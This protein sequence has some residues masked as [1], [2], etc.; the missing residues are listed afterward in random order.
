MNP[1]AMGTLLV[2]GFTGFFWSVYQRFILLRVGG[3]SAE[4]RCDH[5]WARLARVW[6]RAFLH[7]KLYR[8]RAAG[9]AHHLVFIGFLVL[10]VRTLIL[11]GR[12][13]DCRWELWLLPP[14]ST[15]AHVYFWVKDLCVLA[16]AAGVGVFALFRLVRPQRRLTLNAEGLA[17]LGMIALMMVAD[18]LYDAAG[19]ALRQALQQGCQGA[20]CGAAYAMVIPFASARGAWVASPG[21][22]AWLSGGFDGASVTELLVLGHIGF[23]THVGLVLV[24]LN[25]LPYSKHFHILTAIP[26]VFL[27]TRDHL[28]EPRPIAPDAGSLMALVERATD[29]DDELRA[30]L[31]AA[32]ISHYSWKDLLDLYSCTE[33][34]RCTE[35]CPAAQTGKALDPKQLIVGLRTHLYQRQPEARRP[36]PVLH[37]VN[38]VPEIVKPEALWA[39]TTCRACEEECPVDIAPVTK[40]IEMRRNLLLVRGEHFPPELQRLFNGIETNG[41]PWNLPRGERSRWAEGLELRTMSAHPSTPILFWVGCAASYDPRARS[42]A[43]ATAKL[44]QLAKVDFA[45]LGVEESCTGDPARRAGNEHL[46]LTAAERNIATLERYRQAGGIQKI[47]TA[48]PHCY[49]ALT[50]DYSTLGA[51]Y[52]VVH[53]SQLLLELVETARLLP[54]QS[55]SRAAVIQDACYLGRYNGI[56]DAPRRLLAA[57]GQPPLEAPAHSRSRGGCCGAGGARMW[58]TEPGPQRINEVRAD[59]LLSSGAAAIATSCPYCMTMIS[60]GLKTKGL[61][62][63]MNQDVAELLWEA[64]Q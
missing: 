5:V 31:G 61:D 29:L 12:G 42:V 46:F 60:D 34:G 13:F 35:H 7:D 58:M 54:K 10:L 37:P 17:I 1:Y 21:P 25:L 43:R 26:N 57:C 38:L 15:V 62:P 30:P 47:V 16:V 53:H 23:W 36:S 33:C 2:V 41:N 27:A 40:I 44:L 56:Y 14:E 20:H 49:N 24:F 6:R 51:K 18:V 39:C 32:R 3:S 59:A 64:C 63:R 9:I 19:V 11:W 22:L 28:S 48:C 55:A 50:N 8:Y 52:A 45:I 4:P